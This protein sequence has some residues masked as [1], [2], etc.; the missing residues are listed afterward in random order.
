MINYD[1]FYE[2]NLMHKF[3]PILQEY[4]K[5]NKL[6]INKQSKCPADL[7]ILLEREEK[8]SQ[9]TL[10]CKLKDGKK[11]EVKVK[12]PV[13]V[14]L[15]EKKMEIETEY[16]KK[17]IEVKEILKVAKYSLVYDVDHDKKV[18][19]L[20]DEIKIVEG[21]LNSINNIFEMQKESIGE[22]IVLRKKIN[23]KIAI[24]NVDKK[25]IYK[26]VT[27]ITE[28]VKNKLKEILINE[29]IPSSQRMSQ[30][31][32][33]VSLKVEEVE[34]WLK[35]LELVRDYISQNKE[36]HNINM[37]IE[38]KNIEFRNLNEKYIVE[39]PK[40]DLINNSKKEVKL[41]EAIVPVKKRRIKIKK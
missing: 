10:G 7:K 18:K 31:G 39:P 33:N 16:K 1:N 38:A 32:K 24:L 27:N 17:L 22:L 25:N 28:E 4:N 20:T 19:E 35:W 13:I 37:E 23:E 34:N 8:D 5:Y 9:F 15:Y 41:D 36:L 6:F 12:R 11:W 29:G 30:I 40:I 2:D 14:N 26:K 3:E 21:E